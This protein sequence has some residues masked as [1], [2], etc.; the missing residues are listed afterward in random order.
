MQAKVP[1][2]VQMADKI[3]GPLTLKHMIIIGA[4]GGLA[5]LIYTIL[6]RDSFWEV[7]LPPVAIVSIITLLIAFVKIHNVSFGKFALLF[8]EHLLIPRK[9]VWMKATGEVFGASLIQPKQSIKKTKNTDKSKKAAETMK[10]LDDITKVLD[11]YGNN[12]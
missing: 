4:G 3:V 11:S 1:Q 8:L 12:N 7:W 10:K 9:R 2:N 5:Y 6:S